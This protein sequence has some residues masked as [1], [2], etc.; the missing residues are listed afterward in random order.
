M[1]EGLDFVRA[2]PLLVIAVALAQGPCARADTPAQPSVRLVWVREQN[3]EGCSDGAAL[4]RSVSAR[5]GKNVFS[6]SAPTSIEGVIEHAGQAWQA[7]LYLRGADGHLAGVRHLS[8]EGPDCSA[9]DAAATLAIAL[10]IDPQAALR[11]AAAADIPSSR[12]PPPAA[13]AIALTAA[14]PTED[15]RPPARQLPVTPVDPWQR[16]GGTELTGLTLLGVGLL[17]QAAAGV[18]LSAAVAIADWAS[19]TVGAVYWPEVHTVAG[20]FAFGLT[21]GWVGGCARSGGARAG[22]SVCGKVLFGAIHSVVFALEPTE[23][24]DRPWA[25]GALSA[26]ARLRLFG[27]VIAELGIEGIAPMTRDR[28]LVHGRSDLVFQQEPVTGVGFGGLGVTIP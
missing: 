17:P 1:G 9:L 10:A 20:D 14:P 24:G 15:T 8:S 13:D 5:L 3:T 6:D 26:Q 27:P 7:H 22:L 18:G 11:L 16:P 4:V 21:A 23:P 19:A 2:V 28:F 25:G 12:A